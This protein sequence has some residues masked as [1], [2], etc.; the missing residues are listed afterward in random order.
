MNLKLH[1]FRFLILSVMI[2]S[3]GRILAGKTSVSV[4]SADSGKGKVYVEAKGKNSI[5][6][7]EKINQSSM[8]LEKGSDNFYTLYANPEKGYAFKEWENK[9]ASGVSIGGVKSG[10]INGS[11]YVFNKVDN[12]LHIYINAPTSGT[13]TGSL[14]AIFVPTTLSVKSSDYTLGYVIIDKVENNIG[15]VVVITAA[16]NTPH[17]TWQEGSAP[18]HSQSVSFGGWYDENGNLISEELT[19]QYIVKKEEILEA[20][21]IRNEYVLSSYNDGG[22]LKGYFRMMPAFTV[23]KDDKNFLCVTGNFN[24]TI[25]TSSGTILSASMQFNQVPRK[26]NTTYATTDSVFS[27]AGSVIYLTG[28]VESGMQEVVESYTKVAINVVAEAQGVTTT[29][30]I[31]SAGK[32]LSPWL[33]TSNT[34]GFYMLY[35]MN[36]VTLQRTVSNSMDEVYVSADHLDLANNRDC[37]DF[38]IQPVDL[39]HIDVNYFGAYPSAQMEFDGGYWTSMYT[40]FPYECYEQDGVEAYVVNG[41]IEKDGSVLVTPT[42]LESGIVPAAT[43]VLLKCHGLTPKEN[44][45]IPLLPDDP[46]LADAAA[47]TEGNLLTGDYGLWTD[48]NYNGRTD[49]NDDMRVFSILNGELG[50]YKL[51]ANAD[52][53]SRKLVP[54][55][56]YL[57]MTKLGTVASK[58]APVR[59]AFGSSGIGNILTDETFEV[60]AEYYNLQGVR[61]AEPVPGNIYIE[62][63]GDKSKKIL[64]R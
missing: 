10:Q 39:A 28:T 13:A 62:R 38:D 64:F 46:R 35:I 45:L 54:N 53:S 58:Q 14:Q 47:A 15:D 29:R 44:R 9:S 19:T 37:G 51:S 23:G 18:K 20:R 22:V 33:A 30:I 25:N 50:F 7:S 8:N 1:I 21:F 4:S 55:R 27:N 49:Y 59:L 52:G 11:T 56:A 6:T 5:T 17:S 48:N 26:H 61:V 57:D 34:P 31:E 24:P 16:F 42:L 36:G 41:K 40:S 63:R 2:F 12:P 60:P 32:N 3:S 43:P